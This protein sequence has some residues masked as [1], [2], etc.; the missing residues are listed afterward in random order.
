[1]ETDDLKYNILDALRDLLTLCHNND[2][3]TESIK[4]IISQLRKC[5]IV[6][7]NVTDNVITITC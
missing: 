7:E 1:M 3:Y 6:T 4:S 5:K 2:E